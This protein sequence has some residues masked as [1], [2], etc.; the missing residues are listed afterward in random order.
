M[1]E[2]AANRE[3]VD[4]LIAGGSIAGVAAAAA[5][6]QLGLR[7]LIVEPSPDQGRRLAGELVHPPGIDGLRELGLLGKDDGLGQ[8]VQGFAVFSQGKDAGP[9]PMVLPY[10]DVD[11]QRPVGLAIEHT[12]LKERLLERVKTFNAVDVWQGA[13]V[14]AMD[15]VAGGAYVATVEAGSGEPAMRVHAKLILGADGP[16]S[17][18]RKM[19]G[20][21]YDTQRYSGM[22]GT[23]VSDTHLP[24]RG[25]GNIFLNQVGVSYAYAIGGGRVRVMFEILKGADQKESI[26]A[27]LAAFPEDFRLEVQEAMAASKPLAA[28]N[29]CIIPETT[30]KANVALI[31]DARGCCHPLT[32]SGI[33]AAVKDAFVLRDALR[34]HHLDFSAALREYA[35]V[36]DQLQLTRRTL[37]EELREAFL[38]ETPQAKLLKQC[39]FSYWKTSPQGRAESM[40]LL[41]T[42]NSSIIALAV[43]YAMVALQAFRLLPQWVKGNALM[44]WV[45]GVMGLLSKSLNFQYVAISQRFR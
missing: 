18:M 4:V 45:R 40:N 32:A 44:D 28:A 23:E 30:V 29:Y 38:A 20:I 26:A 27:H 5:L 7:I 9:Q 24:H 37:A 21:Q 16:M 22:I 34:K 33:T 15:A 14:T 35:Q 13:R 11:G 2:T 8:P 41:S 10:G 42:L 43:Q 31:G 1:Q 39:I 19:I 12:T 36:C 17:Q 3:H 6:A 25:Y